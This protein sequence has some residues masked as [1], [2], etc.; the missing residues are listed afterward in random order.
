VS[1]AR[2]LLGIVL[3]AALCGCSEPPFT[4]GVVFP[5]A[6]G[7]KPGDN[8]MMR[9]LSIGQVKD[10]DIHADGVLAR[11]EVDSKYRRHVDSKASFRI[12]SEKLV[13]GKMSLVIEPGK[14]PG[15]VLKRGAVLQGAAAGPGPI[16]RVES[17]VND[18]VARVE[19]EATTLRR[20]VTEPHTLPPRAVGETVDL[21]R[22]GR[23]ALRL[24]SVR[25]HTTS[26]DGRDWD[27]VGAGDPDLVA[28]IWV[29]D[30]QILLTSV[31]DG[32]FFAE[33]IDAVSTPFELAEGTTVKVK[34]LDRDVSADDEIG[35]IE[36]RPTAADLNRTF[37][38]S[39]GRVDEL[40]VSLQRAS[41]APDTQ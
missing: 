36:F 9:G 3:L 26:A 33:W 24:Q 15:A 5:D 34:V 14:P 38:L 18:A 31:M 23:Y 6:A 1:L 11:I 20:K 17:A 29:N 40:K 19:D 21:D 32:V 22:Q 25:V 37:R 35:V 8:V 28:Q 16:Q 10:V 12:R 27:G 41:G 39:A 30:R 7:L 2:G 13:T 4:L